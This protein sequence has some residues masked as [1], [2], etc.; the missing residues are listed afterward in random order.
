MESM[1]FC[2]VLGTST[3]GWDSSFVSLRKASLA[4]D[5]FGGLSSTRGLLN[6][7]GSYGGGAI[8]GGIE[9]LC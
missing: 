6:G 2:R 1:K 8:P 5:L 7:G 3:S 4:M 9:S